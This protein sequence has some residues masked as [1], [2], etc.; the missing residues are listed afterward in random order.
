[1]KKL[2]RPEEFEPDDFLFTERDWRLGTLWLALA[3]VLFVIYNAVRFEAHR[4]AQR[5]TPAAVAP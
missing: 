4:S 5:P 2:T 3:I 1:M